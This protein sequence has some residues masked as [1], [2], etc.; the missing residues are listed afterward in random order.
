M[1]HPTGTGLLLIQ[2]A[3]DRA[4]GMTLPVVG[5]TT[6]G[7]PWGKAGAISAIVRDGAV[8]LFITDDFRTEQA[9]GQLIV[10]STKPLRAT[11]DA[12]L[13]SDL[14]VP[15]HLQGDIIV[16]FYANRPGC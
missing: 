14:G 5:A 1:Q 9:S 8:L 12:S 2:L 7:L 4:V 16:R 15:G 10:Q 3:G 11:L 6:V 13:V